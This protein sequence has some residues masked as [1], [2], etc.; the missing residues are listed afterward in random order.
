[1]FYVDP[2]W[3]CDIPHLACPTSALELHPVH[4]SRCGVVQCTHAGWQAAETSLAGQSARNNNYVLGHDQDGS[5]HVQGTTNMCPVKSG[6]VQALVT[7][8]VA[9]G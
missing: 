5:N 2:L 4:P 7:R 1:M 3:Y 6:R 8:D 9:L